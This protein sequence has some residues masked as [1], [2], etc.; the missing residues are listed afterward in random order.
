L[1]GGRVT[2]DTGLA[3]QSERHR[4]IQPEHRG[5]FED[6]W[7]YENNN[8]PFDCHVHTGSGDSAESFR[9]PG[10]E[11]DSLT[12]LLIDY[13]HQPTTSQPFF[14]VLSVQPPHSPYVAPEDNMRQQH[15]AHIQFRPNVPPIDRIRE[16]AA[17]ELAGYYA[18]IERLD[19]NV[20][21]IRAALA[22]AGLSDN[23]YLVFF[24][25]HGDM[26]G[27]HG[28]FRKSSPWEESIRIPFIIGGPS[29]NHQS[30]KQFDFP[31]NHVDIAPTT[32]GLCGIDKPAY[33]DGFD[34]SPW[35]LNKRPDP[36]HVPP[37]SAYMSMVIPSTVSY[38]VD[39][40]YRGIVTRDGWKYCVLEGQP[41][42]LF[43]LKEDPYELANLAYVTAFHGIRSRLQQRLVE[44]ISQTDDQFTLP[45]H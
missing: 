9:L 13:V 34:Y 3:E 43:N 20:G 22:V 2:K 12:D 32:L 15:P 38:A 7:A 6:W 23:T 10:Y 19:W 14:A 27:S 17:I 1:D 26:H 37:D 41:W 44:W 24:S 8:R 5:G 30:R 45:Y 35:V 36:V 31:V 4:I 29:R 42:L 16:T 25:D 11:T 18:A 33:M 21:R 28:L 40:P 39:R